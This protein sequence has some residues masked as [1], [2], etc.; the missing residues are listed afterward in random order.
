M[1]IL[2]IDPGYANTGWSVIESENGNVKL[3][4]SGVIETTTKMRETERF[5]HI[6]KHIDMVLIKH[7]PDVVMVER[8]PK[9]KKSNRV[10]QIAGVRGVIFSRLWYHHQAEVY[11]IPPTEVKWLISG[12][13]RTDKKKLGEYVRLLLGLDDPLR[14]AHVSDAAACA[15]AYLCK[16]GVLG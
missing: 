11:E 13:G 6:D 9:M 7:L 3:I 4:D 8:L 2:G 16:E 14:P 10:M 5:G 12:N 1:K 15:L